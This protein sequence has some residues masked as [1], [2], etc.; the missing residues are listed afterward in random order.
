MIKIKIT[1][2]I[3]II[4]FSLPCFGQ[5]S[6]NYTLKN[7]SMSNTSGAVESAHYCLK[8]TSCGGFAVGKSTSSNFSLNGGM[9][10]TDIK[11]IHD[12]QNELPGIFQCL[13]NYP[14]PFNPVTT[15]EYTLPK[16]TEV[17]IQI[18]DNLGRIVKSL[19]QGYQQ[20]GR[21]QIQW[22]G[23]N[24]QGQQLPSGIYYYQITADEF[25][26]VHKMLLLK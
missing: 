12:R 2:L 16:T 10:V 6:T 26:E 20:Q 11:D 23:K 13:Q 15:I 25:K 22:D 5:N 4:I 1:I 21:H 19:F 17:K 3:F 7:W 24:D 18:Y 8:E 9:V 14:N